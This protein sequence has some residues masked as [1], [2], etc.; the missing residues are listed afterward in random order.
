MRLGIYIFCFYS[1]VCR[2]R[3]TDEIKA[4]VAEMQKNVEKAGYVCAAGFAEWQSGK[5]F[6][7]V[8]READ[9]NM[10]INKREIKAR[11]AIEAAAGIA[12]GNGV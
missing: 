11:K 7:E 10:Y 8:Y 3:T 12:A 9:D 2:G 4:M 1:A 6:N 5:S